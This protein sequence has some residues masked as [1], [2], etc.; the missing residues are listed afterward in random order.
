MLGFNKP[1]CH[2]LQNL[3]EELAKSSG[4]CSRFYLNFI[5]GKNNRKKLMQNYN[6][7]AE[8]L[9]IQSSIAG[10]A[11]HKE[12]SLNELTQMEISSNKITLL[13]IKKINRERRVTKMS[14]KRPQMSF[15][16]T[17]SKRWP[18]R[19]LTLFLEDVNWTKS[20]GKIKTIK[21]RW[22]N[23]SLTK[24]NKNFV[25]WLKCQEVNLIDQQWKNV[26]TYQ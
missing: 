9:P 22:M 25:C 24:T 13:Y 20:F 26:Q 15:E 23:C 21:C 8:L 4:S 17:L 7:F 1:V 19:N 10:Q 18:R 5:A 14:Y 6:L 2:H 3:H 11:R 16:T 12:T